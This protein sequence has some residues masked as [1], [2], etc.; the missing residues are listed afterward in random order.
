MKL[1]LTSELIYREHPFVIYD[2]GFFSITSSENI[3][4]NT[5]EATV[6]ITSES[7]S[8]GA[9]LTMRATRGSLHLRCLNDVTTSTC[10]AALDRTAS[11]EPSF[12]SG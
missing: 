9:A 8:Y 12:D 3:T 1:Q 10:D 6:Y 4:K 2:I 5:K 7:N 11:S